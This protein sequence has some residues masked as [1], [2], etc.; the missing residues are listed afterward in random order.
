MKDNTAAVHVQVP[1]E[2]TSFL[3]NEKRTEITKIELKQRVTVLLVPNKHLETPNYK[4]ERL[5][6][7]DP[8]LENIQA[9]YTMIEEPEEDDTGITRREKAKP[10]QEPVIKGVLPDQPAPIAPPKPEHDV[11]AVATN[12][13]PVPEPT[14]APVAPQASGGF[15]GWLKRLFGGS[16]PA[17]PEVT[18]APA[19]VVAPATQ[20]ENKEAPKGQGRNR[21]DGQR[22]NERGGERNGERRERN[23]RADKGERGETREGR[24]RRQGRDERA[25][26]AEG[27]DTRTE[28][29]GNRENRRGRG[30][31]GGDRNGERPAI[32]REAIAAEAAAIGQA[33]AAAE[34][35]GQ[36]D[37]PGA[38]PQADATE[39]REGGRRRRR[40]GRGRGERE[41]APAQ[42]EAGDLTEQAAPVA[43]L[44]DADQEA[45][46]PQAEG[47]E[48]REDGGRRRSRDRFRRDR[49]DRAEGQESVEQTEGDAEATEAPSTAFT[50][51][52]PEQ[53][54]ERAPVTMAEPAPTPAAEAIAPAP[55][56]PV[57]EPFVL[58][59]DAL[60]ALAQAAGL[61]W[62]NSNAEKIRQAQEAI[63]NEPKPVHIP[64]E[65][66]PPVV[67]DEG[68]L[69]LVETR[70]DL[71][72]VTLPFESAA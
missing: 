10:K 33:V 53:T 42:N 72:Q 67:L 69:I 37:V 9:S 16:Q 44:G 39:Q 12:L 54:A 41:E 66:K 47:S 32:N 34:Q 11:P 55:T 40:G 43:T 2:V 31:R 60:Q 18:P 28:D 15:F 70:K 14:P 46:A 49:R 38:A 24:G 62:V 30:G 6:H 35:Q 51:S 71:N 27:A 29:T 4:L 20:E 50:P 5:R 3:L 48:E 21:R 8:R 19:V 56:A 22:R 65:R 45:M 7:D 23:E 25:Q 26:T 17:T 61:E 52:A 64:R 1:V 36:L 57:I 13:V 58:P 68:P 59:M 63:A